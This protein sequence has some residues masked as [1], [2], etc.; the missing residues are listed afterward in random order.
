LGYR[1]EELVDQ[2]FINF[3][4]PLDQE[5]SIK[6]T[7]KVVKGEVILDFENRYRCQDGAWKIISWRARREDDGLIYATGRD[8]TEQRQVSIEL[9][10]SERLLATTLSS[11]KEAVITF[12]LDY[13]ILRMNEAAER[14]TGWSLKDASGQEMADVL[15][16]TDEELDQEIV[17]PVKEVILT[18][19]PYENSNGAVLYSRAGSVIAIDLFA[20]ALR[21]DQGNIIGA[22][23]VLRDVSEAR[24]QR[25]TIRRQSELLSDLRIV[26]DKFIKEPGK[27][28]AFEALLQL[29]LKFSGSEYGFVGEVLYDDNKQPYLKT[30]ALTN[31]AWTDELKKFYSENAPKGL[32]FR[33]LKTLF[34]A[35]LTSGQLVISNAPVN[36]PRKGG[37]PQGHP[38]LNAFLGLPIYNDQQMVGMIGAANRPGGYDQKLVD[39]IQ[40]VLTT[41]ANL[42]L[43]RRTL[44]SQKQAEQ[45]AEEQSILL[46]QKQNLLQE[47]HHRVKNNLQIISSLLTLQQNQE[48]AP[49]VIEQLRSSRTRIA[50]VGLLHEILYRTESMES[51]DLSLFLKEL[52]RRWK[53]AF[54]VS[55]SHIRFQVETPAGVSLMQDQ[56]ASVA[57]IVNELVT[58]SVKYAF[59]GNKPGL[60]SVIAQ[61]SQKEP[62]L[63]EI[64]V[65][66]DGVGIDTE[67]KAES[68]NKLGS[69]IVKRLAS[70]LNGK[71]YFE[72]VEKGT[73][74]KLVFQPQR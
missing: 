29:L 45:K 56:A 17:L 13:R 40:P 34:G 31:I 51:L 53:D 46:A 10:E 7:E 20:K 18:G 64:S 59:P 6:G 30:H 74:W 1:K 4:H 24:Q 70:Q 62:N 48:T 47:V 15:R 73:K 33:N 49:E 44:L 71:I 43:A 67:I 27:T 32:E 36:D 21:N 72:N 26:Q 3:A 55:A 63:L 60:V 57:L 50:A 66:D 19:R 5:A 54:G 35:V 25:K 58:N 42:I 23:L 69:Q 39:E 37:L 9:K 52:I 8:V 14:F 16:L 22:V 41:Y 12:D 28:D 68:S 2:P 11:I 38:P 65:L 61:L